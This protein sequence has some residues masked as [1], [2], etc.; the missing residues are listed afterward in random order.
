MCIVFREG[1]GV[2]QGVVRLLIDSHKEKVRQSYSTKT[3]TA[4]SNLVQC[5]RLRERC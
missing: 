3:K 4:K 1:R 5:V 2:L